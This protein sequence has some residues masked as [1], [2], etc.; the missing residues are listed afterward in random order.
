LAKLGL[1]CRIADPRD[2]RRVHLKLTRKG[3]QKLRS[4]SRTN[5]EELRRAASPSLS[6][7]LKSFRKQARHSE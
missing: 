1:I 2:A 7:L 3:E 4:L 6:R 5:L